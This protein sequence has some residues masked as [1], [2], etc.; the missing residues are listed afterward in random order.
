MT[1]IFIATHPY[2]YKTDKEFVNF[3]LDENDYNNMPSK[4][5]K[6][7]TAKVYSEDSSWYYTDSTN[8]CIIG[9]EDVLDS[10]DLRVLGEPLEV[11]V[12]T[13]EL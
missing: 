5:L 6:G 9:R 7:L 10:L 8:L 1:T 11:F 4:I 3:G 13:R 12:G 2:N